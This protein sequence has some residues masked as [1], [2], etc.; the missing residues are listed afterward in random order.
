MEFLIIGHAGLQIYWKWEII[1]YSNFEYSCHQQCCRG[2]ICCSPSSPTLTITRF[3]N[4]CQSMCMMW[5]RFQFHFL[6]VT[7][8]LTQPHLL[9]SSSFINSETH[10]YISN[11]LTCIEL[12][13]GFL[14]CPIVLFMY[15]T[16]TSICDNYYSFIFSL[17]KTLN[18]FTTNIYYLQKQSNI[19]QC[20][21]MVS[22]LGWISCKSHTQ[23][24][25]YLNFE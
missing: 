4:F 13:L 14:F 23:V 6:T 2:L 18:F 16:A 9:N 21:L 12:F 17:Y 1:F 25:H 11:F 19:L 22:P 7:S 5:V 24:N 3:L 10:D 15:S 20:S 8:Q